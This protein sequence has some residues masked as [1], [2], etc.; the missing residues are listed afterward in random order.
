M[1][2]LTK[3]GKETVA[4]FI[5]ECAAKRKEILDAQKD[6]AKD[7]IL[8]NE[9]DILAD[10]NAGVGVDEDGDYFNGWGVTDRYDSDT[11]L[12]LSLG[13]DFVEVSNNGK[14]GVTV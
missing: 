8:P 10:I 14:E 13:K 1:Y 3:Q 4:L 12:G 7:T 6:T 5:R 9:A 11:V 2:A